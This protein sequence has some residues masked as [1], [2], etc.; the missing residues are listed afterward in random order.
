MQSGIETSNDLS[1]ISLSMPVSTGGQA[2]VFW[3]LSDLPDGSLPSSFLSC[4]LFKSQ[5]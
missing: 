4:Q 3:L 5:G 2:E 1:I